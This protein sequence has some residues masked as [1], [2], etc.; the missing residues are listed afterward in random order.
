VRRGA[1]WRTSR[2]PSA[3]TFPAASSAATA[4]ASCRPARSRSPCQ[5]HSHTCV[6]AIARLLAH[7]LD[8]LQH[9]T[10]T[11]RTCVCIASV[12]ASEV[13][14]P[15][16][17]ALPH[18]RACTCVLCCS[19]RALS[20]SFAH[21]Q[22]SINTRASGH[23]HTYIRM[24]AH[25]RA[26]TRTHTRPLTTFCTTNLQMHVAKNVKR[27]KMSART[28]TRY[29]VHAHR[30][31]ATTCGNMHMGSLFNIN[32]LKCSIQKTAHGSRVD[33]L[34]VRTREILSVPPS[35]P[36][37]LPPSAVCVCAYTKHFTCENL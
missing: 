15:T 28:S 20:R 23:V 5:S 27:S 9:A 22:A 6:R 2:N 8:R 11:T 16:P 33:A 25:A 19:R 32:T 36:P 24:H 31:Y 29:T 4:A 14:Q 12:R 26:N 3:G 34:R 35:V 1:S 18:L 21:K 30:V 37:S 17:V 10:P 7:T 13:G